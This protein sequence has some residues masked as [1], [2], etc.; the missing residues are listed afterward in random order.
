MRGW[1]GWP[2]AWTCTREGILTKRRAGWDKAGEFTGLDARALSECVPW[3]EY[4]EATDAISRPPYRY[5]EW[6]AVFHPR[7]GDQIV[8]YAREREGDWFIRTGSQIQGP[9]DTKKLC[10]AVVRGKSAT[11]VEAGVYLHNDSTIFTRGKSERVL[12]EGESLP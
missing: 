8:G 10:L 3:E 7:G 11:K 5:G 6:V 12:L 9:F 4:D 2:Q 1:T